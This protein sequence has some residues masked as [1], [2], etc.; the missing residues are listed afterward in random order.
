[1]NIT[2]NIAFILLFSINFIG[3]SQDD[4]YKIAEYPFI[5][6]DQ[7]KIFIYDCEDQFV[8][9]FNKFNKLI[10]NGE[11]NINI[12]QIGDSHIQA[13]YFSGR[14]RQ[15]I[16]T[17]FQGGTGGRGFIFPFT[18]AKTNNPR[19]Y[20]INYNGNWETC[21]NI[22]ND[23]NCNIGLSGIT[24]STNDSVSG[25]TIKL[26]NIDVPL[27][28]FNKINIY[29]A[30]DSLSYKVRLIY[31]N[32]L[33]EL[34]ENF[35]DGIT[36]I[37]LNEYTDSIKIEFVKTEAS[38]NRFELYGM[39]LETNDPGVIYHSIGVN[40]AKT[41]SYLKCNLFEP[42]LKALQPDMIIVSLGTNDAYPK[43]FSHI[44]F[45]E[46]YDALIQKIKK[47]Y[48]D[49]PLLLTVPGDSYRFR[50]YLNED[51]LRVRNIIFDLAIKYESSV[52]DFYSV[53]GGQNSIYL[54]H[55]SNLAGKDRLH[56]TKEGYII[57]GD[58]MF[59][60]FLRKYDEYIDNNKLDFLKTE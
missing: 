13:D 26:R 52:W 29:H 18:M 12:I 57:Q 43:T 53:M 51:L 4:P 39:S 59:N 6:Y 48:P 35:N 46:N 2:R 15:R 11:G 20:K 16:Q 31:P 8:N 1:L 19:S 3:L 17:F 32:T 40:G 9:L 28:D 7:N 60:A 44:K 55:K 37:S 14:F 58:L 34:N 33:L 23:K 50:K 38:Q 30:L 36:S 5:H 27:Y 47:V 10:I 54:W 42:H 49:I 24:I 22:E 45:R 25:L 56:F 41:E 21:R